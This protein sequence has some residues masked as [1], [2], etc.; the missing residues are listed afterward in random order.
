MSCRRKT[1]WKPGRW[2]RPRRKRHRRKAKRKPVSCSQGESSGGRDQATRQAG[3]NRVDDEEFWPGR[4]LHS[5]TASLG[6]GRECVAAPAESTH[7]GGRYL[8]LLFA[9]PTTPGQRTTQATGGA[10]RAPLCPLP[11]HM[12][13]FC[14]VPGLPGP[15]TTG[16]WLPEAQDWGH[17]GPHPVARLGGAGRGAEVA[18]SRH[19]PGHPHASALS[20]PVRGQP[21]GAHP[22]CPPRR[23]RL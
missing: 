1:R 4:S 12:H 6:N 7:A 18:V 3:K 15:V 22:S 5:N 13:N 8:S 23:P 17:L 21:A 10:P 14:Y 11:C 9:A 16:P 19:P 20:R 2:A